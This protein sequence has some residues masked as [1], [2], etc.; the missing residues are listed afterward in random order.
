LVAIALF[1]VSPASAGVESSPLKKSLTQLSKTLDTS[2]S[3]LVALDRALDR[4]AAGLAPSI[5]HLQ[6]IQGDLKSAS[7]GVL[8]TVADCKG[9]L[10]GLK[11]QEKARTTLLS[12]LDRTAKWSVDFRSSGI[13]G[14]SQIIAGK[15]AEAKKNAGNL[16]GV[17]VRSSI[18]TQLKSREP[19]ASLSSLESLCRDLSVSGVKPVPA[20]KGSSASNLPG[21]PI[22]SGRTP[23]GGTGF[24][25]GEG[26][27]EGKSSGGQ[28]DGGSGGGGPVQGSALKQL[29]LANT[30]GTGAWQMLS[31][32]APRNRKEM[33]KAFV[34]RIHSA[35][36]GAGQMPSQ[37]APLNK[38]EME[39]SVVNEIHSTQHFQDYLRRIVEKR[40]TVDIDAPGCAMARSQ[41]KEVQQTV[42]ALQN[43]RPSGCTQWN[44]TPKECLNATWNDPSLFV[45]DLRRSLGIKKREKV[46][47]VKQEREKAIVGVVHAMQDVNDAVRHR[48]EQSCG[49]LNQNADSSDC[50][51]ARKSLERIQKAV[52]ATQNTRPSGCTEWW[53]TPE[54]CLN[55]TLNNPSLLAADLK[56][57]LGIK[58]ERTAPIS[59]KMV[60]LPPAPDDC[61]KLFPGGG[62]VK[63][64]SGGCVKSAK[65]AEAEQEIAPTTV[66]GESAPF[67]EF[68]K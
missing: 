62:Y 26:P 41:I 54:E 68:E 29:K 24:G 46:S 9:T 50:I 59:A 23:I 40:C 42:E 55:V 60:A 2:M 31:Q 52:E 66:G 43:A 11:R 32:S 57:N 20:S 21:S 8:G 35:G 37:S 12:V 13:K 64:P 7:A 51:K 53:K 10:D 34:N 15:E 65:T 33:E 44:K 67:V 5:T 25:I 39:K 30:G 18:Q 45:D 27:K 14:A 16:L 28:G 6:K 22:A 17:A 56:R 1:L 61:A 4:K 19:R 48:M 49:L 36:A 3:S 58:E 38:K 63:T 47:S